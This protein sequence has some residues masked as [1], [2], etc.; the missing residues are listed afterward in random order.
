MGQA[1]LLEP[2]QLAHAAGHLDGG[3]GVSRAGRNPVWAGSGPR[4][5]DLTAHSQRLLTYC[6][7]PVAHL[8]P[9]PSAPRADGVAGRLPAEGLPPGL[10]ATSSNQSV[11]KTSDSAAFYPGL[12]RTPN[13]LFLPL[14]L[15]Q[16]WDTPLPPTLS[17]LCPASGRASVGP[18]IPRQRGPV[19]AE[20]NGGGWPAPPL[21]LPLGPGP[22]PGTRRA[23]RCVCSTK[24]RAPTC[25]TRL[26][27]ALGSGGR[28][29]GG[30]SSPAP[31]WPSGS[32]APPRRPPGWRPSCS[33]P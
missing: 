18:G 9:A 6:Q 12:A 11:P 21:V 23:L 7:P 28:P 1:F 19:G 10:S 4:T 22:Q 33:C 15:Q 32:A 24:P 20:S 13:P 16:A 27:A 14:S 26:G 2:D 3:W 29:G 17:T 30:G 31:C 5:P 8:Y 25:L